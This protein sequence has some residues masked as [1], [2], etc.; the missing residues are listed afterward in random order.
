MFFLLIRFCTDT[1]YGADSW[2]CNIIFNYNMD[3]NSDH[4]IDIEDLA[5]LSVNYNV[6]SSDNNWD[7]KYDLNEDSIIYIYDIVKID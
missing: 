4:T 7:S 3:F 6:T 2:K 1:F 5:S